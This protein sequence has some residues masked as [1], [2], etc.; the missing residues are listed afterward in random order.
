MIVHVPTVLSTVA[1]LI[2]VLS[3]HMTEEG[4]GA[5]KQKVGT[6]MAGPEITIPSIYGRWALSPMYMYAS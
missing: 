2:P 6:T 3:M 5:I 4:G 1:R